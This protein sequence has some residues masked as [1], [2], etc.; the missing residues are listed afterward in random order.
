MD[1]IS[2][3]EGRYR[4]LFQRAS[5]AAT[6]EECEQCVAEIEQMLRSATAPGDCG[7]LLMCRARVRSNQWRT[8]AVYEDAR[9]AM[10]LFERAGEGDLVVDAASWAAAHAS[11][12]GELTVASELATRSLVA[13]AWVEDDRLRM[14]I[15][16]RLGIFCISFLDYDRAQ[17]QFE[18]S[19]AAAE[20]I[21]DRE[22]ICRQLH[23]IADVLLLAARQ[24]RLAHVQTGDEELA[25]AE[26]VVRELLARAT[27][28]F[29]R[30]TASHRLLAEVLCELGRWEEALA[31]LDQFRDQTSGIAPAAQRAALAWI[32]AR[33]LRLAGRPE[34]A[35]IEAERAVAIAQYSDDDH[36]LMLALEELAAC[37]EAAGDSNGALATAREVKASMWTIHQ[38]QTRQLVQEV[39]GRADL[40]RDQATLQSQAAEASRRA[41]EDALT[42]IGNRRILERF[43]VSDAHEQ[44]QLA[45]IVVDIDHFKQIND[46]YGHQIGDAVLRR[47]GHLLR[48]EMRA[49]QVAVRYGGD[50][51]VVGLLGVDL[52]AAA[53]F[54]ERLRR[55]IEELDWSVLAPLLR[56][57]TSLGVASGARRRWRAVFSEA[58]AALYAAKRGGRN[59]VLTAP[60][61]HRA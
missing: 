26:T 30:R 46:T 10:R 49:H 15:F 47:I 4:D 32:E 50:E 39:W 55:R 21:G 53:G 18:A 14:E 61:L 22:K 23:N 5:R 60:G 27:D 17:E 31:V 2:S 37:Q 34:K 12:M 3:V 24:R 58:D 7:R 29:N 44:H 25:R 54:A 57:T 9:E 41:D 38:R 42:G 40:L 45:L 16:N 28:E 13:L 8:A 1:E 20:R 51:F 19:L 59:T 33:C 35:V 56:V 11:R 6:D 52:D 48:D 36:E 43:L